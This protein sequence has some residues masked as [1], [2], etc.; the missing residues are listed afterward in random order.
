[1][2]RPQQDFPFF[3]GFVLLGFFKVFGGWFFF[4]LV[5]FFLTPVLVM[6][7]SGLQIQEIGG[8]S[9]IPDFPQSHRR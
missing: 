1:M 4:R 8:V 3:G 5:G 9:V 2:L 6:R 7:F